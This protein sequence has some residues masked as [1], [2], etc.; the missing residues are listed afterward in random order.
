MASGRRGV[1]GALMHIGETLGVYKETGRKTAGQ[2]GARALAEKRHRSKMS[3]SDMAKL[4][5]SRP[6]KK[7][8]GQPFRGPS[9]DDIEKMIRGGK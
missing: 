8:L 9:Q 4:S 3:V 1:K 2:T 5:G 6:T 7:G